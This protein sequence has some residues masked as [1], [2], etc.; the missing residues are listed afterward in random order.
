MTPSS[1]TMHSRVAKSISVSSTET[2]LLFYSITS[3][4]FEVGVFDG[5]EVFYVSVVLVAASVKI[6][7]TVKS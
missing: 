2:R 7:F 1:S 5:A 4:V 6:N 3:V